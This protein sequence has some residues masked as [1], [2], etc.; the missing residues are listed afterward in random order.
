[1]RLGSN[2]H[3]GLVYI[4]VADVIQVSVDE[5]GDF[6]YSSNLNQGKVILSPQNVTR[7]TTTKSDFRCFKQSSLLN[8]NR[9]DNCKLSNGWHRYDHAYTFCNSF[10]NRA[11]TLSFKTCFTV[12]KTTL[13]CTKYD[14]S[15]IATLYTP[16]RSP[17]C[18]TFVS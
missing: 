1:M 2:S 11:L 5:C 15:C 8:S 16:P 12:V 7:I 3:L 17:H 18:C 10:T 6:Y 9:P 13:H 14:R 4:P